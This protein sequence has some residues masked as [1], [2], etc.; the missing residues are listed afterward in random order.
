MAQTHLHRQPSRSSSAPLDGPGPAP[1]G[2]HNARI[3]TM[4]GKV[5]DLGMVLIRNGKIHE[6]GKK[7]RVPPGAKIIDAKGGTVMPGLVRSSPVRF[8]GTQP[9]HE[10]PAPVPRRGPVRQ[11]AGFFARRGHDAGVEE[12]RRGRL[13]PA[14]RLR[15]AARVRR[16]DLALTPTGNGFPGQGAV[17]DPAG[18]TLEELT[19]DDA[20]FV[21]VSPASGSRTRRCDHFRPPPRRTIFRSLD[22]FSNCSHMATRRPALTNFGI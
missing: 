22:G 19:V 18:K 5:I 14:G 15:R 6:V 12:D 4:E 21:Y 11:L 13:R 17:L 3:V 16:D 7:L 9:H 20:S 8:L 10:P 2:D 1:D